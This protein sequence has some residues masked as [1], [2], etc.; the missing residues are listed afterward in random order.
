MSFDKYD[1]FEETLLEVKKLQNNIERIILIMKIIFEEYDY[2]KNFSKQIDITENPSYMNYKHEYT[3]S[4]EI[5]K[6][7]NIIIVDEFVK[8]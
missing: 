4:N 6:T 2:E 3:N 1:L 7:N 8:K 5:K